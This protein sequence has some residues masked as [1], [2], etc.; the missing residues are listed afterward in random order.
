MDYRSAAREVAKS[1]ARPVYVCYGTEKYLIRE[2]IQYITDKLIDP[3]VRDF[4]ISRH[5]FSETSLEAVLEDAQTLPFMAE[6]KLVIAKS[7][8]F[9]TGAKDTS[10][11]EHNTEKLLEYLKSPCEFSVLIL[12]VDADKLD[13]RKKV[14]KALKECAIAF[15]VL[16]AED[17]LQWVKRQAERHSFSFADGAADQT[18]LYAGSNLQT[19]SAELDKLSLYVG[20]GG[21]VTGDIVEQLVTRSTEQNVFILIEDIVRLRL[22]RAFTILHELIK[23]KEEPVKLTLLIARQFR[24][25]LQVKESMKLGYSQQQLA[26]QLGLHPY[27]VKVAAEQGS[28]YTDEQLTRILTELAE[29]DYKMK[30]GKIDKVL[31]LELFLL[32][33]SA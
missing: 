7:A 22:Q 20:S 24:I 32:Q 1:G 33:L 14:V 29:L 25:I 31:G 13:E 27:A 18:V 10:K 21:V 15:P 28:R 8:I 30:S 17:L 4:A 23:M 12:L 2:F 9:L 5:D 26:G 3:D 11:V 19:L 6:K 16:N